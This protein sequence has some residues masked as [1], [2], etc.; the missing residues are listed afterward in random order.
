MGEIVH[1]QKRQYRRP[2]SPDLLSGFQPSEELAAWARAVFIAP[3]G[4]LH[5]PEHSHLEHATIGFAWT[6]EAYEKAQRRVLGQSELMPP[7]AM[8]KW[9]RGRALAQMS[10]WFGDCPDF[11]ITIDVVAGSFDDASFC[12]LIE[13]ELYHCAQRLDLEGNPKFNQDGD[14]V[15]GIRSH[16]V[17]EFVGVVARYG[18]EATGTT[19]LVKAGSTKALVGLATVELA[20]GTCAERKRA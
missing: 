14:P 19:D 10:D 15:W 8:G 16:D 7:M 9:Q 18:T 3:D 4:P 17:E 6:G 12:A 20:C 2:P 5:N 1:L 11:L 13:H